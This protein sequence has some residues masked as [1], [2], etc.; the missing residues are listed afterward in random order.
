MSSNDLWYDGAAWILYTEDMALARQLKG[1]NAYQDGRL[2]DMAEYFKPGYV[3]PFALQFR[4]VRSLR[5]R[6]ARAAGIRILA[7]A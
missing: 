2:S 1:W 4:L 6:V 3:R 7:E 5:Q